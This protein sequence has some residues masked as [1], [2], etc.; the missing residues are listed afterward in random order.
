[1]GRIVNCQTLASLTLARGEAP[2]MAGLRL[3]LVESWTGDQARLKRAGGPA[4]RRSARAK[5]EIALA[6]VDRLIGADV[7]FGAVL[8]DAGYG[9]SAPFRQTLSARSLACGRSASPV[10]RRPTHATSNSSSPSP[11]AVAAA[12]GMCQCPLR[13]R[14]RCAGQ[15]ELA[16]AHLAKGT[17]RPLKAH[18]AAVRVRVADGPPQRI[19]DKGMHHMPGQEVWLVGEKRISGEQKCYLANLPADAKLRTLAAT[20]TR[21]EAASKL[22]RTQQG[23]RPRPLRRSFMARTSPPCVDDDGRLRLPPASP[24][25]RR[26]GSGKRIPD[27]PTQP[28]LPAMRKAVVAA[29]PLSQTSPQTPQIELPK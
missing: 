14:R 11:D 16:D 5:S 29:L 15:R 23:T 10:T 17:K 13:R 9:M 27:G 19:G 18:F 6:E 21:A 3:F 25:R 7:R 1:L 24:P 22:I 20:I 28:T 26:R 2:A 4:E 12:S 8:A